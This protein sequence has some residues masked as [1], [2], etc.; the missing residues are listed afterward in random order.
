MIKKIPYSRQT[1]FK[2]DV[3]NVAKVLKSDFITRGPVNEKFEKKIKDY[4]G[5]KYCLTTN[6]ATSSLYIAC[7]SLNVGKGDIVWTSTNSFASSAN[8]AA[9]CGA[10]VD[11]ID[12]DLDNYNISIEKLGK[13]LKL[14]SQKKKLPK[15]IIPVHYAGYPCDMEKIYKLKNRYNFKIIED[16][17]HA[18]GSSY[19]KFK[20]GSSKHS[21]LTVFS[22]QAVKVI[23][24]GEGG[25]I[26]TNNKKLYE[27]IKLFRQ[28]GIT[29]DKKNFKIKNN[30]SFPWYYEQINLSFNFILPDINAALGLSQLKKISKNIN[31]REKLVNYYKQKFSNSNIKLL[32]IPKNIK[33]SHHL[34]PAIYNFKSLKHK[35]NF[36][37]FMRKNNIFLQVLY[38]PIY[39]HPYYKKMKFKIKNFQ[40]SEFFYKNSFSLPLHLQ[41]SKKEID[42]ICSK[43]GKWIK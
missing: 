43:I 16:A 30:S 40:N 7:K 5:A 3:S 2:D 11:F 29:K 41:I 27:K 23:T 33:S 25:S 38:I 17:S 26:T 42:Y 8:C 15:V 9:L 28:H 12:I 19:N 39:K 34:L 24:T 4:V 14:A 20:V 21:D 10:Q 18:I 37:Q 13:K 36:F 31:K 32:D 35:A 6:S 22:F 1:I